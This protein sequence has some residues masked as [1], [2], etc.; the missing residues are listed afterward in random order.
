MTIYGLHQTNPAIKLLQRALNEKLS[1]TLLAD[2]NMGKITQEALRVYQEAQGCAE[3]NQYGVCY[4]E[5]TQRSLRP[6]VETKYL[7][8]TALQDTALR[9]GVDVASVQAVTLTE[10]KEF[11]F[12]PSGFPVILFERHKFYKYLAIARGVPFAE[13]ISA[14]NPEL[15][16][17]KMGGYKGGAAEVGRLNA[18][19]AIDANSAYLSISSGLFQLM[20]FNFKAC[21]YPSAAVMFEAM[22]VSEA[23]QLDA[24]ASFILSD[25]ALLRALRAKDWVTFARLY[26]G[27]AYA[28]NQYHLKLRANYILARQGA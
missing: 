27:A 3:T 20:G 5:A 9:L 14:L 10:A 24:F 19:L 8:A 25:G 18:A 26:N 22:K 1:L 16:N 15:C 11:G 4:G 17:P 6:F 7:S 21:G 23:K 12:L 2:G 28:I 13:K